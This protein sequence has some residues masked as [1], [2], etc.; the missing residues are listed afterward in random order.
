MA[1][2][3]YPT[4]DGDPGLV[5]VATGDEPDRCSVGAH[6]PGDVVPPRPEPF[7]PK[8]QAD[9]DETG[10]SPATRPMQARASG[11]G[12]GGVIGAN[13]VALDPEAV[14]VIERDPNVNRSLMLRLIAGV[15][16]L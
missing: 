4:A 13:A 6:V 9:F 8:R 14:P 11:P 5:T 12:N 7:L 1:T 15:R 16:G 3:T 2:T 10:P